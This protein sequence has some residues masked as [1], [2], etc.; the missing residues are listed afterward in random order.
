MLPVEV[1]L[2]PEFVEN[3]NTCS[4]PRQALEVIITQIR[5][6]PDHGETL[7]QLYNEIGKLPMGGCYV[8]SWNFMSAEGRKVGHTLHLYLSRVFPVYLF[9]FS[10]EALPELPWN[11][12]A[13]Q[14]LL[15]VKGREIHRHLVSTEA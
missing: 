9:N 13:A 14:T 11:S 7:V 2:L 8:R 1:V 15:R 3:A 5:S 10:T 4:C 6:N 12:K